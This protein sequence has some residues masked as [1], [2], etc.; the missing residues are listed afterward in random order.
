MRIGRTKSVLLALGLLF[1]PSLALADN[2]QHLPNG[3]L[4]FQGRD[5]VYR[6]RST[7]KPWQLAE[8]AG[9]GGPSIQVGEVTY[10]F[11][12]GFLYQ[13]KNGLSFQ[14]AVLPSMS[15]P[16][17]IT[18]GSEILLLGNTSGG[19]RTWRFQNGWKEVT[20]VPAGVTSVEQFGLNNDQLSMLTNRGNG[21]LEAYAIIDNQWVRQASTTCPVVAKYVNQPVIGAFCTDGTSWELAGPAFEPL[22]PSPSTF[23]AST[24]THLLAQDT[25]QSATVYMVEPGEI[26]SLSL[27]GP[28]LPNRFFLLGSR[29]LLAYPTQGLQELL[30]KSDPPSLV[31]ITTVFNDVVSGGGE[32]VLVS[33]DQIAFT[34]TVAGQWQTFPAVGKFNHA[35][36][37]LNGWWVWQTNESQ[38]SGGMAQF[39]A[40]G[41]TAFVKVNAWSSTTSPVQAL[42]LSD[43]DSYV[44]VITNSGTGNVNLYR[45]SNLISWSRVSLPS[46]PVLV[47]SIQ[48]AREL[49]AGTLVE[50]EGTASVSAGVV[51]PEIIYVQDSSGGIQIYL[52]S[53]KG[54]LIVPLGSL[55]TVDGEISS[56]EVQRVVLEAADDL[57]IGGTGQ[58]VEPLSIPA[59][60]A[61]D[62]LGRLVRLKGKVTELSTDYLSFDGELRVHFDL[63]A[64]NLKSIFLLGDEAEATAIVDLNSS[65]DRIEAWY[66]GQGYAITHRVPQAAPTVAKATK[67]KQTGFTN[68]PSSVTS[69]VPRQEV[70]ATKSVANRPTFQNIQPIKPLVAADTNVPSS[71]LSSAILTFLGIVTGML[72]V[73]GRRFRKLIG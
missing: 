51:S 7:Q 14:S 33:A 52:S 9:L 15:Q 5:H 20:A 12:D 40:N 46:T 18:Q 66:V 53:S 41:Q 61:G 48:E 68:K 1:F 62:F 30:W 27:S 63:L 70:S 69:S 65:T 44:S 58:V 2:F 56:S 38:T 22:V 55:V 23:I 57:V 67:T 29:L 39:L 19:W 31:P 60:Q 35:R 28:E 13:T 54:S 8:Q 34:S 16:Q 71:P 64:Q 24:V 21:E 10:F 36:L 6:L 4:V 26:T 50:L 25:G 17:F 11:F 32:N 42:A 49:L 73:Q 59:S 47:R 45:S 43:A 37:I 3:T 72:A